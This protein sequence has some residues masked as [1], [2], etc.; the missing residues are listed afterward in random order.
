[1]T[2][3]PAL[4]GLTEA[5]W[6]GIFGRLTDTAGYGGARAIQVREPPLTSHRVTISL[7]RFK[8]LD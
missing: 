6:L 7:L 8:V 1:M 3:S 5:Q 4:T 2:A